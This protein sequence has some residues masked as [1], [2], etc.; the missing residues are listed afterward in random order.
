MDVQCFVD[1]CLH[2]ISADS[3]Q[4]VVRLLFH[5]LD[6]SKQNEVI[7]FDYAHM[8]NITGAEEY[9]LIIKVD[10]TLFAWLQPVANADA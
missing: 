3:G 2:C 7:H 8:R 6:G 1:S 4:L 10:L 9:L 5:A